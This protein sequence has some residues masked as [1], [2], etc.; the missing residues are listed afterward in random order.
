MSRVGIQILLMTIFFLLMSIIMKEYMIALI[1]IPICLVA[2]LLSFLLLISSDERTI[3]IEIFC[4][5]IQ[6]EQKHRKFAF[7]N[8]KYITTKIMSRNTQGIEIQ[9]NKALC[10]IW[11]HE[12]KRD[13][14]KKI[15]E[16]LLE[17]SIEIKKYIDYTGLRSI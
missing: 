13:E 14:W 17:N 1:P 12:F 8:K 2:I 5:K 7:Q 16:Y 15:E 6:I 4:E 3:K 11:K 10:T 9:E